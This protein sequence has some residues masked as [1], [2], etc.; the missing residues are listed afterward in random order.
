MKNSM[1][2]KHNVRKNDKFLCI[3]DVVMGSDDDPTSSETIALIE[4]AIQKGSSTTFILPKDPVMRDSTTAFGIV[5]RKVAYIKGRVYKSEEN[6]CIT[7]E[8]GDYLH[9]WT[10]DWE[11]YFKKISWKKFLYLKIKLYLCNVFQSVR[12][13]L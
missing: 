11:E 6:K 3:N 9:K 12:E 5:L 7:D 10:D 1:K 2:N 8:E 13:R 4:E